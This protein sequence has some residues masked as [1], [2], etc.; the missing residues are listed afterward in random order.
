MAAER[1]L[2]GSRASIDCQSKMFKSMEKL[3]IAICLALLSV[4]IVL[5]LRPF[6]EFVMDRLRQPTALDVA[7]RILAKHPLADTHNDWPMKL[8]V[9]EGAQIEDADLQ[10][11]D[12]T[13]FNTDITRLRKGRVSVQVWSAYIGCSKELKD[14]LNIRKTLEQIDLIKRVIERHSD[15]FELTTKA[16]QIVPAVNRGKIASMIG[17]E[18]GHQMQESIATLR[19]YYDLGVRYMTLTHSCH[20]AWADSCSMPPWHHGLTRFGERVVREMNRLGMLVDISHVSHETMRSVMNV[21]KAPL[22][23]SHSSVYSLCETERNVPDDVL[24]AMKH[25]DGVVMINFWPALLTCSNTA[26]I[27]DVADHI[28]YVVRLIGSEHVGFGA[29]F[30]GLVELPVGLEDVSKYPYLV[31]SLVNR[32]LSNQQIAGIIGGNFIR[33]LQKT[34]QVA[35][36]LRIAGATPDETVVTVSDDC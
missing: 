28:M 14:W 24:L 33:V 13:L 22:F 6:D 1:R 10:D 5:L 29:D 26:T 12:E 19:M 2:D 18:G 7:Y 21:T 17:I 35:N 32:G 3:Q 4:L 31:A 20:T 30:D 15:V 16:S 34:E 11:M 23:L 36:S 8:K 27:E 25:R 9:L